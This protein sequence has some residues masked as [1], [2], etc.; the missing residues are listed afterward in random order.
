MVN[1]SA[2]SLAND[3]TIAD[4]VRAILAEPA[5]RG[6]A[7]ALNGAVVPRTDWPR[8]PLADGDEVEVLTAAQGG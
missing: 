8:T 6:V 2:G 4:V 1:G 3:T 5:A 7:V